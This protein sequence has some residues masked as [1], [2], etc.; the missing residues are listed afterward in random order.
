MVGESEALFS[1][2]K[3]GERETDKKEEEEGGKGERPM[4]KEREGEGSGGDSDDGVCSGYE[5]LP[6]TQEI[7]PRPLAGQSRD[8]MF[9]SL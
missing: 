2:V 7:D 1:P 8:C 5:D 6:M 9:P 4:E 3:E